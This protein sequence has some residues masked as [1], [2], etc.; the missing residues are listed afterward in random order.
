MPLHWRKGEFPV[1]SQDV[2][3]KEPP[4]QLTV[5]GEAYGPLL[6]H[7]SVDT[8]GRWQEAWCVTHRASGLKVFFC[9]DWEL[10]R[11]ALLAC[12]EHWSKEFGKVKPEEVSRALKHTGVVSWL[13]QMRNENRWLE[14]PEVI[15]F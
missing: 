2:L 13:I 9:L 8:A 3:G 14:P 15:P 1:T 4:K 12:V 7:K 11:R 5:A 10:A 6:L